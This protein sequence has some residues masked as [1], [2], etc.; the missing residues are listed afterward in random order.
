[1]PKTKFGKYSIL[2]ILLFFFFLITFF[3]FVR[4]GQRGGDT[5][6]SNLYLAI[7]GLLAGVSAILSFIFGLVSLIK[8]KSRSLLVI[9]STI[10]G[11]LITLFILAEIL[12][13]H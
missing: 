7:P 9:I 13:P 3:L 10:I 5:F 1:M 11:F 6:F 4:S 2:F 12:F 8:E